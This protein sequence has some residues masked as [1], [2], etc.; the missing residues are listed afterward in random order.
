[1]KKHLLFICLLFLAGTAIYATPEVALTVTDPIVTMAQDATICSGSNAMIIITGPAN[2]H[3]L[4]RTSPG[5]NPYMTLNIG[6]AGTGVFSTGPLYQTT[7]YTLESITEFMTGTTTPLTGVI[8]TITVVFVDAPVGISPQTL[9]SGQ[10]L[11]SL[12][13]T[14][15]N[16][17]WY[18]AP[19]GGNLLPDDTVP[20]NNVTYYAT[21]TVN[22][23][24]SKSAQSTQSVQSARLAVLV[25]LNLNNSEFDSNAFNIYPNPT[26]DIL[27]LTS[28]LAD[29]RLDV[30]NILSQKIESRTLDNG[31]N[32]IN[33]SNLTSGVYLF[34]LSLDGKTRTYKIVK[35]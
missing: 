14:G 3:V 31:A 10:T 11:S 12:N 29:V 28:N 5:F 32:I 1:M 33:L 27:T 35:N 6:P 24:E 17:Q 9:T 13:V 34:Q 23:C 18:D 20:Q 30:F 16:I 21:Q 7:T 8:V 25:Q 26:S 15:Q 4:L 2:S 22:N 19:Q